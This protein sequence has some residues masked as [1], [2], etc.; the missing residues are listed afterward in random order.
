MKLTQT[1]THKLL[2]PARQTK[3]LEIPK[4]ER[5]KRQGRRKRWLTMERNKKKKPHKRLALAAGEPRPLTPEE[6]EKVEAAKAFRERMRAGL[7]NFG[8]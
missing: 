3:A 4:P 6:T 7:R 8:K 1:K 2:G 5:R